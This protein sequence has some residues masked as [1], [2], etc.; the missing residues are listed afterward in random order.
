MHVLEQICKESRALIILLF[1]F[2]YFVIFAFLQLLS[3]LST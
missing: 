1:I 3:E 2:S